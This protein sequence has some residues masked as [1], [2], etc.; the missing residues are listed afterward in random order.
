MKHLIQLKKNWRAV[1]SN[2]TGRDLELPFLQ[3]ANDA[4]STVL[5]TR[6][7]TVPADDA[8]EVCCLTLLY[9]SGAYTVRI[10]GTQVC[11][12]NGLFAPFSCDISSYVKKGKKQLLEIL[13]HP[14]ATP[15]GMYTFGGA[16]LS[17]LPA[18]HFDLT[19]PASQPLTIKTEFENGSALIY[20]DVRIAQP[21]NYDILTYK[22]FDPRGRVLRT[23]TVKPT[24]P[25][26]C[27]SVPDPVLWDGTDEQYRYT[28]TAALKRDSA[29]IDRT[30]TS[31]GLRDLQL[32]DDG[33]LRMNGM[34]VPLSGISLPPEPLNGRTVDSL[35]DLACS[36][37]ILE[38]VFPDEE[39]LSTCDKLGVLVFFMFP[40]T[41]LP[42][43]KEE[44]LASVRML[45]PHPCICAYGYLPQDIDLARSFVHTI[46]LAKNDVLTFGGT[47]I[48]YQQSFTDAVPDILLLKADFP[49]DSAG[50]NSFE[51]RFLAACA[52]Q[53][54]LRFAV[55]ASPP[56][57]VACDRAAL[58]RWHE[59][60]WRIFGNKKNV[61]AYFAGP[62][63]TAGQDQPALLDAATGEKTDAY[64]FY[65]AQF[66]TD[67]TVRIS[68]SQPLLTSERRISLRCLS[69][70]PSVSLLVNGKTQQG[71]VCDELPSHI[72]VFRG[73]RLK[74][75]S[76]TLVLT[77]GSRTDSCVIRRQKTPKKKKIDDG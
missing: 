72:C 57:S 9:L 45:S 48:L 77:D 40:F 62:L 71:V 15:A 69:T 10:D 39:L 24:S 35:R 41:D 18:T 13:V 14:V 26:I 37:V 58:C 4:E 50:Q 74:H 76:N 55:L 65:R 23:Q 6:G 52:D 28:L 51:N 38:T 8:H 11:T 34:R 68:S 61:T 42:G 49:E 70:D 47:S 5:Y 25:Q 75:G 33:L 46:R 22:L 29:V 31:F 7:F 19:T 20:A 44:L 3:S 16:L 32:E 66:S 21:T 59:A 56:D 12:H 36:A 1:F 54:G 63:E 30:Q 64:W 60:L 17:L 67:P 43:G 53:P 27:V 73:V 2:G